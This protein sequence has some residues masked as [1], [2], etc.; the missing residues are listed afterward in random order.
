[1][2]LPLARW[3]DVHSQGPEAV[4]IA[5]SLDDSRPGSPGRLALYVGTAP[6]APRDL[7][8]GSPEIEVAPGIAHRQA[9][10]DQAQ[11][12]LRP[13]HE[14]RWRRDDLHLRL[15]GQGPW[16]LDHLLLIAQSVG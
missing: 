13:V 14:L 10:L 7:G 3:V 8:G 1:M 16:E 5:W 11:P 12:S 15:T 9:P 2:P 6:P 4:E